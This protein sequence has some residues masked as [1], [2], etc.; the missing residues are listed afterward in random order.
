MAANC[1]GSNQAHATVVIQSTLHRH[2]ETVAGY[3]FAALTT[4]IE[5]LRPDVFALEL[6]QE[7]IERRAI[8]RYKSEYQHCVYPYLEQHSTPAFALEPDEPQSS[9]ILS[10]MRRAEQDLLIR[11]PEAKKEFEDSAW[12]LLA[13]LA[14]EW[15]TPE[16]VNSE[17]T[18]SI[19]QDKHMRQNLLYGP[20]YEAAWD[21]WNGH[22][23]EVIRRVAKSSPGK[24][25]L[26]LVGAEHRYWLTARLVSDESI[27]LKTAVEVLRAR[28][29]DPD[30]SV[31]APATPLAKGKR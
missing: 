29:R 26:V 24:L 22:F 5:D 14:Q 11:D 30:F 27:N 12:E 13:G 16:A 23:A 1:C 15:R 3:S 28:Q 18:D 4:I 10:R 31:G 7:G 19:F 6:T 21:E 17:R 8:Q 9:E 2:H 25:V 20:S